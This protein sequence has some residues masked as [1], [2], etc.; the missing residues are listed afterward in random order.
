MRAGGLA[1]R[2]INVKKRFFRIF[3]A[4]CLESDVLFMKSPNDNIDNPVWYSQISGNDTKKQ[5]I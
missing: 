2:K 3:G 4:F 5:N 1:G